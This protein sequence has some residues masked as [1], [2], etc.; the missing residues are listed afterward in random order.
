M[1]ESPVVTSGR[2]FC[3]ITCR[4]EGNCSKGLDSIPKGWFTVSDTRI[5]LAV[6][7]LQ[8]PCF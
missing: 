8:M 5:D 1:G 2:Q 4:E 3:V 7:C 6:L